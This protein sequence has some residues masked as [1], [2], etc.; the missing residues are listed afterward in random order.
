VWLKQND[1][2][3][4]SSRAAG[5]GAEPVKPGLQPHG[6][7]PI[8]QPAR[9]VNPCSMESL[10]AFSKHR[11]VLFLEQSTGY[12]HYPVRINAQQIAVIREVM[13][14]AQRKPVYDGCDSLGLWVF[15]DVRGLD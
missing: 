9:C 2:R 7:W 4:P 8:V 15:D 1:L 6:I 3:R 11:A 5:D 10:Q 12:V 14:R 13:D